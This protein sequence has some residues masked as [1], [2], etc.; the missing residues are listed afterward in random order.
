[1]HQVKSS[2]AV[3]IKDKLLSLKLDALI[4]AS[5][6]ADART[7]KLIITA[8]KCATKEIVRLADELDV[9]SVPLLK[10]EVVYLKHGEAV[11]VADVLSKILSGRKSLK[12]AAENKM[13]PVNQGANNSESAGV[14]KSQRRRRREGEIR[15]SGGKR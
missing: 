5:I 11:K 3:A 1:M 6:N 14:K 8:S 9:E 15:K 10:S 12:S 2:S 13:T 7:N 4:G